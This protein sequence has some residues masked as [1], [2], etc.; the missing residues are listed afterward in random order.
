MEYQ[1]E[2]RL[3][4][5]SL[6]VCVTRVGKDCHLLL[7]GGDQP[8]IGSVVLAVS[9]ESL[10][11]GGGKSCTSSVL[12]LT[13]HKDEYLCRELAEEVCR[14]LGAVTL[15]TG[16]FHVDGLRPEQLSELLDI[17]PS[18]KDRILSYLMQLP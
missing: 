3:S 18:L 10:R 14:E 4:F 2:Q 12:N 5:A 11:G 17:L 6:R 7:S 16:G 9:R 8:H 1:I 15:C 13:G